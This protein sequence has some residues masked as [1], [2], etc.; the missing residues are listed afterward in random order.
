MLRLFLRLLSVGMLAGL[1]GCAVEQEAVVKNTSRTFQ[2][3]VVDAGHGGKDSGAVRRY[4]PPEK[5]VALDVAKR[6]D[7][8]LHES[9]LHTVMTRT[10]DVF[11]PLDERVAMENAQPNS[12]FVSIHFNDSRRRGVHGFETYYHS[13]AAYDLAIRV[14]DKLLT[15]PNAVNR[16]VHPANFRVLRKATYP[17]VL[18]ECGY[19]SNRGDGNSAWSAGYRNQLADKIAEAIVEERFGTQ[20][21]QGA[22]RTAPTGRPTP[23]ASSPW[24]SP[25]SSAGTR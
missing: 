13:R 6:V 7:E 25:S 12:V 11:I 23:G 15:L 8:K 17:A 14:Q 16:G 5:M 20:A 3:V 21:Y 1:A 4:G 9:R 10:T 2:T 19:L 22:T 24:S 18:V